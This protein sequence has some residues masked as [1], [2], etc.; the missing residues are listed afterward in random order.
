MPP[1]PEIKNTFTCNYFSEQRLTSV[2]LLLTTK[3][4]PVHKRCPF[5]SSPIKRSEWKRAATYTLAA[6]T[7]HL[8]T[9]PPRPPTRASWLRRAVSD[10]AGTTECGDLRKSRRSGLLSTAAKLR[11]I[12]KRDLRMTK[13]RC[14]KRDYH[15]SRL[16]RQRHA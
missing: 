14:R 11:G 6:P 3:C 1:T 2:E 16:R 5:R 4:C 10:K 12:A 7:T 13:T 9:G 8:S 15:V